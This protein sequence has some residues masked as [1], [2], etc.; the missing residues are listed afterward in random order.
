MQNHATTPLSCLVPG[1]EHLELSLE[2]GVGA[3]TTPVGSRQ[4]ADLPPPGFTRHTHGTINL[5]VQYLT[6]NGWQ[7][8]LAPFF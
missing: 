6:R 7:V 8:T 3:G 5:N 1:V 4:A 2:V